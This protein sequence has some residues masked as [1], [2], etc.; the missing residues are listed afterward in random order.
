MKAAHESL[1]DEIKALGSQFPDFDCETL[2][3]LTVKN[4][5]PLHGLI[6]IWPLLDKS[7]L[8]ASRDA[9]KR[10]VCRLKYQSIK[11]LSVCDE[12]RH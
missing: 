11:V 8:Y 12:S 7:I 3:K 9:A 10:Y 4:S 5:F 6:Y 2:F 1:L